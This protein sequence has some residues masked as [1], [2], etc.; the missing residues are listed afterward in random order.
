MED[1]TTLII[2]IVAVVILVPVIV[3]AGYL[4][5]DSLRARQ[6]RTYKTLAE[7]EA[8]NNAGNR[9]AWMTGVLPQEEGDEDLD[10]SSSRILAIAQMVILLIL[11]A[12]VLLWN[13]SLAS[14]N[15][16]QAERLEQIEL[17]LHALTFAT[18]VASGLVQREVDGPPGAPAPPQGQPPTVNPMQQACANLI[19]R[20]ADAYEKGENSKIAVSLEALVNKLGCKNNP[21]P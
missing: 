20:V 14:Q 15:K 6:N 3:V 4:V 1:K 16:Q 13:Q 12:V 7:H 21:V 10:R 5:R 17:Q 18:P 2:A 9:E 8:L 11:A 19:G